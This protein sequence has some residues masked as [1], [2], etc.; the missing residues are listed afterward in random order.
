MQYVY[1]KNKLNYEYLLTIQKRLEMKFPPCPAFLPGKLYPKIVPSYPV[2]CTLKSYLLTRV[3]IHFI[4]QALY[5]LIL[6]IVIKAHH[7]VNNSIRSNF[8]HAVG[9]G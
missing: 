2:S 9:D 3:L 7:A 8:Y 6:Q 5:L 1:L 4:S